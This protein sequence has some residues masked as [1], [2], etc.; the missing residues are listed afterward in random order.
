MNPREYFENRCNHTTDDGDDAFVCVGIYGEGFE[1]CVLCG[2]VKCTNPPEDTN[3]DL[4]E[5]KGR[6]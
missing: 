6:I 3:L 5:A 2:E 4:A 1:Q